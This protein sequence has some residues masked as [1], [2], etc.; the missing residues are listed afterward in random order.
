MIPNIYI[1]AI[2]FPNT[3]SPGARN[4]AV[5]YGEI[6]TDVSLKK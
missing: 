1:G 3:N 2:A 6:I 4:Y 5:G